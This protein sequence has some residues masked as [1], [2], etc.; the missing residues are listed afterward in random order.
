MAISFIQC[1]AQG[2]KKKTHLTKLQLHLQVS[3][4]FQKAK[5]ECSIIVNDLTLLT[6]L[7]ACVESANVFSIA[8]EKTLLAIICC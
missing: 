6:E 3:D 2:N 7:T 4:S 5:Y 1:T 8:A